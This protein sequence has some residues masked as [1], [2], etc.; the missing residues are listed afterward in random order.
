MSFKKAAVAA[1][2]ALSMTAAPVMAQSAAPLSV[3]ASVNRDSQAGHEN[4]FFGLGDY[5]IPL[6][7]FAAVIIAIILLNKGHNHNLNNPHSP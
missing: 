6:A 1:A 3:A 4:N 7:V 2:L 5:A